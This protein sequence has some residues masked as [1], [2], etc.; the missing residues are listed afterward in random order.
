MSTTAFA[1]KAAE[2][3]YHTAA[4]E[5]ERKDPLR[6]AQAM[7]T[8]LWWYGTLAPDEWK[9]SMGAKVDYSVAY[10]ETF[11]EKGLPKPAAFQPPGDPWVAF[12]FRGPGK[13]PPVT[14]LMTPYEEPAWYEG[15]ASGI[16]HV[17]KN[18]T[19]PGWA[20]QLFVEGKVPSNGLLI[21]V[22]S[23]MGKAATMAG[24][25]V[26]AAASGLGDLLAPVVYTLGAAGFVYLLVTRK[27]RRR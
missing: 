22:E 23:A 8:L 3:A 16:V 4:T 27:D 24:G 25:A 7:N 26:G 13:P 6:T 15:L 5:E 2:I 18:W 9:P 11:V 10:A 20:Y 1:Q 19:N 21:A 14:M 12:T 17:L